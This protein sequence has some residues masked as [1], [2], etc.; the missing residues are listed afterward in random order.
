[1][2][3]I[4]KCSDQ[5]IAD[6]DRGDGLAFE[7]DWHLLAGDIDGAGRV[8]GGTQKRL[9]IAVDFDAVVPRLTIQ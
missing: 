8:A 5:E 7:H 3:I 4:L 1:M 2:K 9:R 6:T